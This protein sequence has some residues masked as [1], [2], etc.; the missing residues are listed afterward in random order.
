MKIGRIIDLSHKLYPGKEEYGLK[1]KTRFTDEVLSGYNRKPDAWYILSDVTMSSHIGT[2]IE[3]PY[4]HIKNGQDAM[5]FPI[6]RLIG[7]AVLL[8]FSSKKNNEAI[9]VNDLKQYENN[10]KARDIVLI[11]TGRDKFYGTEQ[12]HERPYLSLETVEWL[13]EKQINC[14]GIDTTGIDIKGTEDQ[15]NHV[16]LFESG[17]PLIE[18][19]ANLDKLKRNRFLIFI[20]PLPM[21]GLDAS[22]VR[23]VAIENET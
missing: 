18:S 10:I 11:K 19:M 22:P 1:V 9:N 4:H 6:E 12:A 14:L 21:K 20:L 17:I 23:I 13:V 15:P 5:A 16:A 8:D 2:H 7:E 3:F